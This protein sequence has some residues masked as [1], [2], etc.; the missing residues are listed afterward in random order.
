MNNT[1]K[2]YLTDEVATVVAMARE[3]E[4][5]CAD[6]CAFLL[7][8]LT[9]KGKINRR[10]FLERVSCRPSFPKPLKLGGEK[11]WKREEVMRWAEDEARISRKV[12]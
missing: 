5:L 4:W 7:G 9:P 11:K 6:A 2:I 10:G 3:G 1:E 8:M 12:A